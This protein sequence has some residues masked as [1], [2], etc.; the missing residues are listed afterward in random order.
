[1][2]LG[3]SQDLSHVNGADAGTLAAQGATDVHQAGRVTAGDEFCLGLLD[4]ASLIGDHGSGYLCVLDG[5]GAAEATAF[6]LIGKGDQFDAFD[7]LQ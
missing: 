4:V 5:E 2:L 3:G 7:F 6:F 1:M